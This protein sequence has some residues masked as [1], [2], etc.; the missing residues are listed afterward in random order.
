MVDW[1]WILKKGKNHKWN[2]LYRSK[3]EGTERDDDKLCSL[4]KAEMSLGLKG[5]ILLWV[6]WVIEN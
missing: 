6:M 2:L 1:C 5:G 3:Q 4:S